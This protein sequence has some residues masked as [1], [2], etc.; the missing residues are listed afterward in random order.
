VTVIVRRHDEQQRRVRAARAAELET[1]RASIVEAQRTQGEA[2]PLIPA[3]PSLATTV[4]ERQKRLRAE[5]AAE[6]A[7]HRQLFAE[8]VRV[9]QAQPAAQP[10]AAAQP[11]AEAQ[12]MAAAAPQPVAAT[13]HGHKHY[14]QP[15]RRRG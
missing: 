2:A 1:L 14:P 10:L 11:I 9:G 3:Q 6:V 15:P 5:R 4:R 12:P 8:A 13:P 7:A